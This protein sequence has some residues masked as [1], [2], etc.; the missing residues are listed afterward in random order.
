MTIDATY[1]AREIR[2]IP[3]A[4][5]RLLGEGQAAFAAAGSELRDIDPL[6]VTTIARGSSDH[7]ATFLKYAIELTA[8]IPVA[9][10]G[11][12]IASVYR[13]A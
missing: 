4:T 11:P 1:M 2:E 7:A 13:R 10:L 12:S 9:S 8:G 5:A 3:Q 6:F